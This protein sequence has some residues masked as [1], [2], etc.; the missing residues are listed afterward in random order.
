V[1]GYHLLPKTGAEVL[2]ITK[3]YKDC[4]AFWN[5]G[6]HAIAPNTEQAFLPTE[7]VYKLKNRFN[8]IILYFD[9][10]T[11]GIVRG[12]KFAEEFQ[13][14]YYHNPIGM[15]KDPTD[16]IKA[17]NGNVEPFKNL[18]YEQIQGLPNGIPN[19]II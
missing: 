12:K 9:N 15:E 4:G 14:E 13:L 16:L 1:Q 7:Y 3:S 10:D 6:F 2:F 8:R 5:C 18:L 17:N 19:S 11:V